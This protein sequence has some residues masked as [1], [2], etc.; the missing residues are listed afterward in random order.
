MAHARILG[1]TAAAVA[2]LSVWTV[3]D[4]F[5]LTKAEFLKSGGGVATGVKFID[6][7]KVGLDIDLTAP[8]LGIALSCVAISSSGEITRP[9]TIKDTLK[10]TGAKAKNEKGETC[11]LKSPGA[12]AE[13][14]AFTPLIGELGEVASAEA[15]TEVGLNMKPAT[16]TEFA[17]LEGSCL[18]ISPSKLTGSVAGEA[19]PT[20]TLST[21]G[22][23]VFTLNGTKQK[24][25]TVKLLPFGM[26][27]TD[28][29]ALTLFIVELTIMMTE[30]LTYSQ[31]VELKV[32]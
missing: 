3:D 19:T 28:K 30:E 15:V 1:A 25:K 9:M 26:G 31:G 2:A 10:C 7:S 23:L 32:A 17:S 21:H 20:N 27:T 13:E 4:A 14:I 16:G 18:P 5:A 29:P 22:E 11:P 6:K 24:I 12:A 8:A